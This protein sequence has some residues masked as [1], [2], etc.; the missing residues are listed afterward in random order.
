MSHSRE[1]NLARGTK[2]FEHL[3]SLTQPGPVAKCHKLATSLISKIPLLPHHDIPSTLSSLS[4]VI[5]GD[6]DPNRLHPNLQVACSLT[7]PSHNPVKKKSFLHR[8]A[9]P[10]PHLYATLIYN[11]KNYTSSCPLDD[12]NSY[13]SILN[14]VNETYSTVFCKTTTHSVT[15]EPSPIL[16]ADPKLISQIDELIARGRAGI[17]TSSKP[18]DNKDNEMP[19]HDSENNGLQ[20]NGETAISTDTTQPPEQQTSRPPTPQSRK[21]LTPSHSYSNLINQKNPASSITASRCSS[22]DP[23]L[24]IS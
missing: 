1:N 21:V 15:P 3:V 6:I 23:G 19:P 18:L 7:A 24:S 12:L 16:N 11:K 22:P 5:K 20:A 13:W 14:L 9:P 4:E 10:L 17:R 8:H 2:L